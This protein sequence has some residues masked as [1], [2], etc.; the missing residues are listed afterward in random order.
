[1]RSEEGRLMTGSISE[2]RERLARDELVLG[3]NARHSRTSEIGPLLKDCGFHWVMLDDEHTPL[4]PAVSYETLLSAARVGL[5]PFVRTRRNEHAEI[6]VHLS[7]GAMGVFVPH[8]N[9]AEEAE[10]AAKA[11]RYPPR[12]KLSVPGAFPQLGYK[13]RP[14]EEVTEILNDLTVVV[15]MI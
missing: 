8:V 10:H 1:R 4:N 5:M 7:N 14:F 12:G 3:M 13:P 6:G 15:C 11:C 9:T 2:F